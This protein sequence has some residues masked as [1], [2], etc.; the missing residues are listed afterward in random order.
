MTPE[1]YQRIKTVLNHR[2]PDLTVVLE[3][4]H[5]PHNLSAIQRTSD[6]VGAMEVHAI[7]PDRPYRTNK[8]ASMGSKKWVD[9]HSHKT[10]DEA[11]EHLHGRGFRIVAAFLDTQLLHGALSQHHETANSGWRYRLGVPV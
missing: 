11:I 9:S 7:A 1:R 5:K 8:K 4:V 10:V 3:G 6:A 2:Q